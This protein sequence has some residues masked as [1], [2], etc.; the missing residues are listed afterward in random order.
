MSS[1]PKQLLILSRTIRF[2]P[3]LPSVRTTERNRTVSS[4]FS[5]IQIG[6]V[7]FCLQILNWPSS[8]L[9][10]FR[11]ACSSLLSS[12]LW[13]KLKALRA[14]DHFKRKHNLVQTSIERTREFVQILQVNVLP[15]ETSILFRRKRNVKR[16][17]LLKWLEHWASHQMQTMLYLCKFTLIGDVV[18]Q[19]VVDLPAFKSLP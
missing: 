7:S 10:S 19:I 13:C 15:K 1:L 12:S 16:Y 5:A 9:C 2:P 18:F 8:N 17:T 14:P 6:T 11:S 3:Q 4:P